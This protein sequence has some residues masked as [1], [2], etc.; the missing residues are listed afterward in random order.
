MKVICVNH[1][2]YDP[3]ERPYGTADPQIGDICEV[4]KSFDVYTVTGVFPCYY[5]IGYDLSVYNQKN[6]GE[7]SEID[8]TQHVSKEFEEKYCVPL[9]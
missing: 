4:E 5:L 7:I 2:L 1:D 6:F 9:K 3:E 8:E